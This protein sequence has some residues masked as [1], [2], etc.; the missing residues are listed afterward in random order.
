MHLGRKSSLTSAAYLLGSHLLLR[1]HHLL[2][3]PDMTASLNWTYF[4]LLVGL[5]LLL[6]GYTEAHSQDRNAY[7]N[8]FTE[9]CMSRYSDGSTWST[10]EDWGPYCSCWIDAF[11]EAS[12]DDV[13][14][15][16]AVI[17]NGLQSE[18][19]ERYAELNKRASSGL[20]ACNDLKPSPTVDANVERRAS[21][22]N[23][24]NIQRLTRQWQDQLEKFETS[25]EDWPP[26]DQGVAILTFLSIP[27]TLQALEIQ[28]ATGTEECEVPG[29][30]LSNPYPVVRSESALKKAIEASNTMSA[31]ELISYADELKKRADC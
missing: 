6:T 3:R 24:G 18:D 10:S 21:T 5:L 22:N 30:S 17:E 27:Y 15:L 14:F 13:K 16:A 28:K 31:E 26:S 20:G 2:L 7:E 23:W 25:I 1:R 9:S 19:R 12:D 11:G 4:S 29:G 8:A